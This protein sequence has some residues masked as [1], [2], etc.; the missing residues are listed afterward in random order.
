[1]PVLLLLFNAFVWGLSWWPLRELDA[2][3][4]H[5]LWATS[6]SFV[7]ATLAISVW[8]PRVWGQLAR[9][10]TLVWMMLAAGATNAAFN[11]GVMTGNVVR[12]VLLF[13]LMP[14]WSLLL[15]RWL[16]REP[17]S[18]SAL[19]RIVV[20]LA[21]AAIVLWQPGTTIPW[22]ASLPDWLGVAGGASFA[23]LNVLVRRER[24]I[25]AAARALSGFIGGVVV[26]GVLA[27]VLMTLGRIAPPPPPAPGWIAGQLGLAMALLLGNLALQFGAARLPAAITAVVMLS[28]VL[29]AAVSAS[30]IG[31]ETIAARTLVGGALIVAATLLAAWAQRP[32]PVVP[33]QAGRAASLR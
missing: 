25:P 2:R 13:Y 9:H 30:W 4:L 26:A 5:G 3:G 11:W 10:P 14:A 27:V 31:G 18:V 12:V 15:A 17:I 22:P 20:A 7:L 29:F 21:G 28:E 33:D 23:L 24:A 8:R 6:F 1:M 16:L 32:R 19:M